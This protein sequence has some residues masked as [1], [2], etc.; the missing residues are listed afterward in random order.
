MRIRHSKTEELHALQSLEISASRVF[1]EYDMEDIANDEPPSL[2]ILS[3]CS[4]QERL[5][6]YTD[7][8]DHPIAYVMTELVDDS[9]HIE[10]ISVHADYSG[11]GLGRALIEHLQEHA[12]K[13]GFSTI[14]LT[15]FR[16]I[17][18]NAPYYAR[19]GFCIIEEHEIT[20][21]LAKVRTNEKRLK[22]DRWPRVCMRITL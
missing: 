20:P 2:S 18:W 8:N 15:T 7:A 3:E 21:E 16:D 11:N 5:W 1:S 13:S 10:Q 17:P 19:L 12:K 22:L 14:T 4:Q 9:M 6:V